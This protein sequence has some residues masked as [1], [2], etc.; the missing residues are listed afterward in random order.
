MR[1][2]LVVVILLLNPVLYS[3]TLL[4]QNFKIEES[5]IQLR[6][7]SIKIKQSAVNENIGFYQK[8]ISGI[9]GQ[10]CPMYPSCSYYGLK[11]FSETNFVSAFVLT[12]DRLLRCGHDHNNYNLTLRNNGF[13]YLDYPDYTN[14]P[15]ELIYKRN[16]YYFAYSDTVRD[17]SDLLFIKRLIN[18]QFYQEALLEIMRI[19]FKYNQFAIDLFINK[20]I[21]LKALGE[22]EKALFEYENKCPIQFKSNSELAFQI[23][24]IQ[25]KLQNFDLALKSNL[26]AF[27]SCKEPSFKPKIILLNGLLYANKYD[28]KNASLSYKSLSVY[29]S[30][31]QLSI[32]NSKL[33]EKG[34]QLKN[35][36]PTL[37][38]TLSI[39]PGL[40]YAYTGHKQ[41]AI[42][43]FFVNSLLSYAT[44]TNIKNENYGMGILT[45]VFNLS[46]Y[47]GNI[48]GANKSAKRFN[49]QRKR[50]I[51]NKLEFN[52]HF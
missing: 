26:I 7:S 8:Y 14:V 15:T 23:A 2:N 46:F 19:E 3:Y 48:Y 6:D 18:N 49:E 50:N 34:I 27:E 22:Y 5:L 36:S 28:W 31:K 44:Y 41:T 40:G 12:S 32:I 13:K 38:A 17:L 45:G 24:L 35:K 11:T 29:D 33:S 52:S 9:R 39:L 43:A 47:A 37:A 10:E 20:I 30:Y 42:S 4:G 25:Y 16:S 51:I 21:C 1:K